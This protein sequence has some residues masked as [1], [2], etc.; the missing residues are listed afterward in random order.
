[1][2]VYLFGCLHSSTLRFSLTL[3]YPPADNQ[4]L[5]REVPLTFPSLTSHLLSVSFCPLHLPY[6]PFS[7]TWLTHTS[8]FKHLFG[9]DPQLCCSFWKISLQFL[10]ELHFS[11][12]APGNL[13]KL[14]L[15]APFQCPSA[16]QLLALPA[17]GSLWWL[18]T[19]P[20]ASTHRLA[21][22]GSHT[23]ESIKWTG[24]HKH[25]ARQSIQMPFL[26]FP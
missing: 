24:I 17:P 22:G 6:Q 3:W 13:V 14:S 8:T 2:P 11:L 10:L 1:M 23:E 15:G 19:H 7:L 5:P 25:C 21:C 16:S 18:P 20:P 26:S 4:G 12:A 9:S